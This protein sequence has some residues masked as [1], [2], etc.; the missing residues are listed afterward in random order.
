MQE[1]TYFFKKAEENLT[2][3]LIQSVKRRGATLLHVGLHSY[4]TPD[5]FWDAGFDVCAIDENLDAL[6]FSLENTGPR[7]EYQLVKSTSLPFEDDSFDY[8]FF[9]C[10]ANPYAPYSCPQQLDEKEKD[11][12]KKCAS[13]SMKNA[14]KNTANFT[15]L[16]HLNV[17]SLLQKENIVSAVTGNMLQEEER[18]ILSEVCRVAQKG[19]ILLFKNMFS[20]QSLIGDT[21]LGF[22]LQQKPLPKGKTLNPYSLYKNIKKQYPQAQIRARSYYVFPQNISFLSNVPLGYAMGI[23]VHFNASVVTGLGVLSAVKKRDVITEGLVNR[24]Q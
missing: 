22:L 1:N 16:S 21:A 17:Q 19:V 7:I 4:I 11:T 6:N 23:C 12:N 5:F 18:P 8:A 2:R 10:Y 13:G 20:L 9:S 24:I 14:S 15:Y 3:T